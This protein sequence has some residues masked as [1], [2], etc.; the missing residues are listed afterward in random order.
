[1]LNKN[2][3][4][5]FIILTFN[6]EKHISRC[7]NSILPLS[8]NIF[9]IDSFSTDNT[10]S[11]AENL[12]AKV[13]QNKWINYSKQ[14][15]WGLDNCSIQTDWIMRLDADEYLTKELC[16]ELVDKLSKFPKEVSGLILNY[17]HYFWGKW[18][19]HGTRYPLPLLRI[20]RTG[21]GYIESKWMDERVI[22]SEGESVKLEN[23]FIHDDLNDLTF[24]VSKHNSYATREAIDLLNK[25]YKFIQ[26]GNS[27]FSTEGNK[28]HFNL[29]MKNKFYSNS[30]MVR[31]RSFIYFFYRYFFRLGFLDGKEGLAYHILQGFWY[32]FLVD[33]KYLEIEQLAQNNKIDIK[34]AILIYSGYDMNKL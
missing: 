2:I 18:I 6:E 27:T 29:Y 10:V 4:I 9:I 19:K 33:M 15:N 20:W 16:N 30:F 24:F 8:K 17:R 1:M 23:D 3:S 28:I 21:K 13:F 11:I 32:R 5:S 22:L 25:K 14:F 31:F 12:G 34:E 7:I 26:N